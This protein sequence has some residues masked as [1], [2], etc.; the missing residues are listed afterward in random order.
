MG[1]SFRKIKKV[2]VVLRLSYASGRDLLYGISLYARRRCRWQFRIINYSGDATA[3]EM[4]RAFAD[5]VDGIIAN[6]LDNEAFAKCL[7]PSRVPLCVIGARSGGLGRRTANLAFVR[8]DDVG[9]GRFGAEYLSHLGRFRSYGYVGQREHVYVS[10]LRREGFASYFA[11]RG[12]DVRSYQ[13][14]PG[15][16]LGSITDLAALGEW[17]KSLPRPAAVMAVHDLR[18]EQVAEAAAAADVRIPK[19]VALIGVDNDELICETATPML[20]SIAPDHVKL[21]EVAAETLS[22]LMAT[23]SRRTFTVHSSS[24][25]MVE[26]QSAKPIAPAVQLV[27]RAQQFIRRNAVRGIGVRDVVRHLGC[28]R[29]LADLRFR[30]VAGESILSAILKRRLAEV[31]RLV[32][33]TDIPVGKITAACGFGAKNYA[34]R[35][36]KSRFGCSMS[37]YRGKSRLDVSAGGCAPQCSPST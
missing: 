16:A 10:R 18:A 25:S 1:K 26:R 37:E 13:E 30:E 15:V 29:C 28:S 20:T 34:K 21:G 12:L 8:N 33:E 11:G 14:P 4:R 7:W 2:A 23:P 36:F 17:L 9:I 31:E 3:D 24:K 27:E 35:L 22:R 5:G 6:G 32:R 19:D